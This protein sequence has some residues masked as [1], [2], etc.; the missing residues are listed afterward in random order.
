MV[1]NSLH[2]STKKSALR[3]VALLLSAT[4][5]SACGE[6]VVS[7]SNEEP[8]PVVVDIPIAFVKRTLPIDEE[9]MRVV[10][11][12]RNPAEFV[13][14]AALYIKAR[15]AV[16]SAEINITDRAFSDGD[17]AQDAA[18]LYDV[19]DI[20]VSYDG[21]K[22][23]FA[24]RAPEI[25]GADE[26]E[27]PTWNIW[28][29]DI[30]TDVLRRVIASDIVAEAGEDT[31]PVYLPDGRIVFSSTR[32][33]TNQ[34]ILIDEGKAQYSALEESL[35][36][37]ASVLHVMDANGSDIT[38][39]SFN[40]SHDIDPLVM[41]NGK[42]LFTRWDQAAGDKGM[43]L[44]Q[45]NP[46]GSEL[47]IVYGRHS[48]ELNGDNVHFVQS[49]ITPDGD[50]LAAVREYT[51]DTLGGNYY[52]ID[53]QQYIDSNTPIASSDS[54]SEP[55]QA[56]A[57]F[58]NIDTHAP[59]SAGGYVGALYPLFDGSNRQLFAWS[60]CRVYDPE[61]EVA[62]DETRT[63]LPCSDALL[64]NENIEAAP[65]L[66]GLWVYD[67][68]TNT[69][70]VIATPQEG[71]AYTELVS[72][73]QRGF[74]ADYTPGENYDDTLASEGLGRIHI[75]SVY[76]FA[77]DD[78]TPSG[79]EV[80]ANPSLTAASERPVRFVRVVKSVSIPDDEVIDVERSDFGPS[81]NLLMRDIIGYSTVEPDGSVLLDLPANIPLSFEFLDVKGKRVLPRHDNWVQLVPGEVKTC[82]GCHTQDSTLPHGR[83]DA[84]YPSIN[85]GAPSTGV[86]HP[87]ANPALFADMGETMA[88]T[89]SRVLG[90]TYPLADILYE[91][92]WSNPQ[93]TPLSNA[94]AYAYG[95]M[96][97]AIPISQSCAQNWTSLCRITINYPD[98]IQPLFEVDRRTFD[99]AGMLVS[100]TTCISCHTPTDSD[101]VT[102]VPAAQ[103]D[104]TNQVSLDNPDQLTGYRELL[105]TDAEVELVDGVLLDRLVEAVD[106]NGNPIFERD[107]D[108][109]LILD[110]EGNPIV[111]M[112][113][114]SVA[115]SARASSA[116][117]SE[118]FFTLFETG[119][120]ANWLSD[121]ELKL[122]AEWLDLGAQYYNNPFDAP[123]D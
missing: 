104:L 57:L 53:V 114:V 110:P 67:P 52:R 19:K 18:P 62:E 108:G 54:L 1:F 96:Q 121:A 25:E 107:E 92:V 27:Q 3:A 10:N 65:L 84:E 116:L 66:Y 81:R 38:Q 59:I 120:H 86:A 63:I 13:P 36:V 49:R 24:M 85:L 102:Q 47:E 15:A 46:D 100:D 61:Q 79:I 80:M 97:S 112:V 101:G 41:P 83:L 9:G 26:D 5:V 20:E 12:L 11:D 4:L 16:S 28:E 123:Q 42:I 119:S 30:S 91:D 34:A 106:G 44:Y 90:A 73:E 39:I 95:D 74:P 8:D 32:Q 2:S 117:A 33:R 31:S 48:H 29:Y 58:D 94:F 7:Q 93:N 118:R 64:A 17:T 87:G 23:L 35:N 76:D 111:V 103:L 14:G 6:S 72:M 56:A 45:M 69:Q 55:G 70:Q 68:Q 77:G 50:V 71:V 113:T 122:M 75:R 60:Q 99:D 51:R 105:F 40:Q 98:H 115:P 21:T 88:Q 89:K 37:E 82:N 78:V 43:H 109:E 22:L